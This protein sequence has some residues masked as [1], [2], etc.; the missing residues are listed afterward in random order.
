MKPLCLAAVAVSA[1]FA[2][3][4]EVS[5]RGECTAAC[6]SVAKLYPEQLISPS[7]SAYAKAQE[8]Y[9]SEQQRSRDPACFFQ[10]TSAEQVQAA[11][12]HVKR[13]GCLFSIKGGG[14]SY[15]SRGS[16]IDGG[17]QFDLVNLNQVNI[18]QDR[19]SLIVGPGVRW[20]PLFKLLEGQ[21]LIAVGGRDVGVGVPGFTFGGGLSNLASVRGWAADNLESFD[22]VL[23]SGEL[24]TANAKSNPDLFRAVRGGGGHNF[25]IVVS[26]TTKLY[27]YNG[28]WG[29]LRIHSQDTFDDLWDAYDTYIRRLPADGKAHLYVDFARQNGSVVGVTF[30]AYPE[31]VQDPPVFD[32]FRS[33]P[34]VVDTLRLANYSDLSDEQAKAIDSRGRRNA[35]WTQ[36]I[37]FDIDLIK[38]VVDFWIK[39][40]EDISKRVDAGLDFN[41]ITPGM[42]N[43]AARNGTANAM[44]LEGPDEPLINIML[45]MAWD[46]ESLDREVLNTYRRLNE[47]IRKLAGDRYHRFK[48]MNY[49]HLEQDVIAS[50]GEKNKRFLKQV[51]AKFDPDSIFQKL[52]PGGF[53]LDGLRRQNN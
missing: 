22:I 35:G 40:T 21:G 8:S 15:N 33:I 49:A 46:D 24:V 30:M 38:S 45:S 10:P 43:W 32:S 31:P 48:Y 6:S 25:G 41:I 20:G 5:T 9:W 12:V 28:M 16:S 51:A 39:T 29:G 47:G 27:D 3:S 44:G 18:H 19:R 11:I 50:Y 36:A 4:P 37:E 7:S 42:R 13:A 53:K 1:V 23:A 52:Q 17:F 34:S 26:L 14:H 2:S